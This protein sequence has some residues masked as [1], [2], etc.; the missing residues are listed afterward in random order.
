ME[1]LIGNVREKVEEMLPGKQ[2]FV[3]NV[4]LK[5]SRGRQLLEV[6][7]DGD[8]GIDI[9]TCSRLSRELSAWLDGGELMKG[10]YTLEVGS[11]GVDYPLSSE[12]QYKRNIGRELKVVMKDDSVVQG[13]LLKAES[14]GIQ[15]EVT[16]KGK[17]K[18][19]VVKSLNIDMKEIRKSTVIV[20]IK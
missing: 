4:S 17:G 3:V 15:L 14:G 10:R 1:A 6:L 9:G 7:V 11:P 18:K 12:R 16:E 8:E 13:K 2:Y 20:A 19:A 5:G